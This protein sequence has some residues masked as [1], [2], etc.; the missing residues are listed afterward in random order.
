MGFEPGFQVL[1]ALHSA[2]GV[3]VALKLMQPTLYNPFAKNKE[4]YSIILLN[5]WNI[6]VACRLAPDVQSHS[7][8]ALLYL[9]STATCCEPPSGLEN[10]C[11]ASY[12]RQYAIISCCRVYCILTGT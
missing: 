9:T 10:C 1:V 2:H 4:L 5:S 3:A 8:G 7:C 11:R 12:Y 6:A